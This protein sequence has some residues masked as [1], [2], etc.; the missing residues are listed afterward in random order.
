MSEPAPSPFL[1]R[2]LIANFVIHG[3]A[4]LT[5]LGMLLPA[6]PGGTTPD[7]AGRV[8]YVA[9]HPWRFRLGWV[10]WQLTALADL[11]MALAI[12]RTRWIPRVPAVLGLVLTV[13]AVIPDQLAQV[14]F[15]TRGVELARL[16]SVAGVEPYL[17]FEATWFPRTA[18]WA[19]CLYT[20]AAVAWSVS[21]AR[22]GT[23]APWLTWVSVAAWTTF[24][25][26]SASLLLPGP[27]RL[28]AVVVSAGNALG[29]VLFQVW[30]LGVLDRVMRRSGRTLDLL[31]PASWRGR[32]R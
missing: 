6:L 20:A 19:A 8:A 12:A 2:L 17:A 11:L 18:S 4:M 27:W 30:I 26:V 13:A 31:L 28:P 15:Q 29:F 3:I 32:A 21:F 16:S 7:D 10:P 23:W 22:A 25:V 5:M 24:G 14:L 9:A 1:E